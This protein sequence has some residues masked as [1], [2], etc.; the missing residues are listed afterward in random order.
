[1]AQLVIYLQIEKEGSPNAYER[2]AVVFTDNHNET[3]EVNAVFD[4]IVK[5]L[6]LDGYKVDELD[7]P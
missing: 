4:D 1:M 2:A 6:K 7:G 3:D 5:G